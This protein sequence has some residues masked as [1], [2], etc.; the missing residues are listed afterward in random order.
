MK[1]ITGMDRR[2]PSLI[3]LIL[4][5]G[6]F[7][8]SFFVSF[9]ARS[10]PANMYVINGFILGPDGSAVPNATIEVENP[11]TEEVVYRESV[12]DGSYTANLGELENGWEDG[13]DIIITARSPVHSS[14]TIQPVASE[15]GKDYLN[16]T[17]TAF[18]IDHPVTGEKISMGMTNYTIRL[19]I[20]TTLNVSWISYSIDGEEIGNT[21][22]ATCDFIPK[23]F[24]EGTHTL[25]VV[26]TNGTG[27]TY[28]QE[29][30]FNLEKEDVG[31]EIDLFMVIL[32]VV[33]VITGILVMI[34][35]KK[36]SAKK[37]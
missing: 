23:D 30:F 15:G 5:I 35:F 4:I 25:R 28:T 3:V 8:L 14:V 22:N 24:T 7:N 10:Q 17:L 1:S 6:V 31:S 21:T 11:L 36:R 27:E 37:P 29:V 2:L 12:E 20:L 32:I 33:I 13:Q 26:L 9:E 34:L 16:F 18:M 19:L